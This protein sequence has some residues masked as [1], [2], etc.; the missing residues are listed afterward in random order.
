MF[1]AQ[2]LYGATSPGLQVYGPWFQRRGDNAI[3]TIDFIGGAASVKVEVFTK[4]LADTGDGTQVSGSFSA[5][6]SS[7]P[8]QVSGSF[9]GFKELVRYRYSVTDASTK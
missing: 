6:S 7:S 9:S 8:P 4:A 1:D 2:L 5:T 3:F